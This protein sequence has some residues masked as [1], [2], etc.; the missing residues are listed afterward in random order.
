MQRL[1]EDM[2]QKLLLKHQQLAQARALDSDHHQLP[3]PAQQPASPILRLPDAALALLMRYLLHEDKKGFRLASKAA[4]AQVDACSTRL[5]FGPAGPFKG[6]L[7][8]RFSNVQHLYIEGNSRLPALDVQGQHVVRL[9]HS[10]EVWSS[11]TSLHC[12]PL[13]APVVALLVSALPNLEVCY[14]ERAWTDSTEAGVTRGLPECLLVALMRLQSLEDLVLQGNALDY[15]DVYALRA[16]SSLKALRAPVMGSLG[17]A[18]ESSQDCVKDDDHVAHG[19]QEAQHDDGKHRQRH[20]N[21]GQSGQQQTGHNGACSSQQEGAGCSSH[22]PPEA[23]TPTSCGAQ[24]LQQ[25]QLQRPRRQQP[26][27]LAVQGSSREFITPQ[28]TGAPWWNAQ[29]LPGQQEEQQ[30]S[31]VGDADAMSAQSMRAAVV[32]R[33]GAADS[34]AQVVSMRFLETRAQ[35]HTFL[36]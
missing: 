2:R 28:A 22:Q 16:C 15:T 9:V 19:L 33:A 34:P 23:S 10:G 26:R 29:A 6:G 17:A 35:Q 24:H 18:L 3:Q 36:D 27:L 25:Q 5:G 7:H 14:L 1:S 8:R 13:P 30:L 4:L 12:G 31:V 20:H 21:I 32:A 11:V